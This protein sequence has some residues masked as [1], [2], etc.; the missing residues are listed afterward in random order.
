MKRLEKCII[1]VY[2]PLEKC[3]ISIIERFLYNQLKNWKDSKTRKPLILEGARQVGKTWL[4]KQ[5]G[6]SR[7]LSLSPFACL[8][9]NCRNDEMD[10][11]YGRRRSRCGLGPQ[12]SDS[13]TWSSP[14]FCDSK[15]WPRKKT[16]GIQKKNLFCT[17]FK[18]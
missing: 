3:N 18:A 15:K 17:I 6:L 4:L 10:K 9:C 8:F 2:I 13:G 14:F 5:F 7:G 1:F 11:G 12:W 16:F